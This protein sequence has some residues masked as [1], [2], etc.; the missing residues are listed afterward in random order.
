MTKL[1][2]IRQHWENSYNYLPRTKIFAKDKIIFRPV[3]EKVKVDNK[4]RNLTKTELKNEI[5]KV[6]KPESNLDS[7]ETL[8]SDLFSKDMSDNMPENNNGE[9][10]QSSKE[11]SIYPGLAGLW[12]G[13]LQEQCVGVVVPRGSDDVL[14]LYSRGRHGYFTDGRVE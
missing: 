11:S 1:E 3:I 7:L 9:P 2:H 8:F 4:F 10:E 12:C 6:I 13:P 5:L 14:Q